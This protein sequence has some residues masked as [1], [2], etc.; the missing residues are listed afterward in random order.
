MEDLTNAVE[1]TEVVEEV[2]T[3]VA[4]DFKMN[5]LEFW[6]VIGVA[7]GLGV[8]SVKAFEFIK[9]KI[10]E[11]KKTNKVE[12]LVEDTKEAVKDAAKDIADAVEDF[13]EA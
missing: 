6:G 4:K 5:N 11:K 1:T 10:D 8:A 7:F 13:T 12:K 9:A 2:A 3:K